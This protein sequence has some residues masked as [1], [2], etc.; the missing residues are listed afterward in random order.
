MLALLSME[1]SDEAAKA[2][3]SPPL[4]E[5]LERMGDSLTSVVLTPW[6]AEEVGLYLEGQNVESD[7]AR[8]A[9]H[10]RPDWWPSSSATSRRPTNSADPA[11]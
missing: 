7:A 5:M 4:M 8:I 1:P 10:I 2:W 3:M 9:G 6:G 11:A